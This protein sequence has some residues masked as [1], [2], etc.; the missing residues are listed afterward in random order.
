MR[1]PTEVGRAVAHY[2]PPHNGDERF[3]PGFCLLALARARTRAAAGSRVA[4][5]VLPVLVEAEAGWR[6]T[7]E[8]MQ[9]AAPEALDAAARHS[10]GGM[11]WL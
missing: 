8:A 5:V 10:N 7:L 3:A 6:A 9:S 4:A 2:S 1:Q 11:D